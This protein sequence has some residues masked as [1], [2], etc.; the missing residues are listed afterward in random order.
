MAQDQ[1]TQ[2]QAARRQ[3]GVEGDWVCVGALAGTHG[4]RGD[5]RLR[6]FTE[7]PAAIFKLK[8]LRQGPD[9]PVAELKKIST[10]KDGF[11]V[12]V[13]GFETPEAAKALNGKQF[14]VARE[15]MKAT[16]KDEFY[17]ADL[18]G[19]KAIDGSGDELGF[20][21]AV[22]NFG[23]EDLLELQ[24]LEPVKNLGRNVFIPFRTE[25]V[26]DVDVAAGHVV[27]NFADWRAT[28]I[29]ERDGDD[30]EVAENKGENS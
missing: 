1:N 20:I 25:L 8:D 15:E 11:I 18:I 23:A 9:G 13:A 17:L 29:S 14:Y 3:V 30:E 6:S 5:V 10:N 24:L 19:L 16:N 2:G 7:N 4:V 26:P 12:H 27:I 28:Q 21:C 22:E